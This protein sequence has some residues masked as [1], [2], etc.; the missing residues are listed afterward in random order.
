MTKHASKRAGKLSM[1]DLVVEILRGEII[2]CKLKPST[3]LVEKDLAERFHMSKTPVRE[4]LALLAHEGLV[5]VFPRKGYIVTALSVQDVYDYFNLRMV[6]ECAAVEHAAAK[7]TDEQLGQL[8]ELI[9]PENLAENPEG[10]LD[11][12]VEFHSLIAHAS[13]NERLA[14]LIVRLLVEMKRLIT[15]GWVPG[16]HRRLM[17]ALRK[18]DPRRAVEAMREHILTVMDNA[19]RGA[20][21]AWVGVGGS[22]GGTRNNRF[23]PLTRQNKGGRHEAGRR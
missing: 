4:A 18:R 15:V 1:R 9:I 17:E 12:N 5:E 22:L 11:R 7:I 13:G 21:Q 8:Q 3:T 6:L 16:E 14:R 2:T 20:A 23:H 10:M 19:L